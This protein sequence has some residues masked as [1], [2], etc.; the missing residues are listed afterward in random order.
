MILLGD[1]RKEKNYILSP[2][3]SK[4]RC[5]KKMEGCTQ[6]SEAVERNVA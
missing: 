4:I 1:Q 6:H 3:M 2:D 5:T